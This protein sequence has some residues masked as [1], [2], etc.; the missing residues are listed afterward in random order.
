MI[1]AIKKQDANG[2]SMPIDEDGGLTQ[3]RFYAGDVIF[4]EGM[5]SSHMYVVKEGEVDIY[6]IREE[7]RVVVESLVRG[8]CFGMAPCLLSGSRTTNAAAK[9]YCEL[10]LVENDKLDE[11]LNTSAKLVRGILRTL[12]EQAAV[13]NELIA[14]RVNYQPDILVYA[15]LLY[16][17]GIADIGKLKA[18]AVSSQAHSA[19][20]S[21]TLSDVFSSARALLGHSDAHIRGSMGKLAMLHLIRIADEKGN[22]KRVLFAPKDIISQARKIASADKDHG[23]LDY[24]YIN[25]DEFSALVD[26]DRGIILKKLA[27][28]E[29][30]ED[31][32][33]FRK[34]EIMRLL[35]D[36]GRK[37]FIDRKIKSPEEFTDIVDIEFADQKTCFEVISRCD[38]YDL[39]KLVGNTDDAIVKSRIL[40]C[41][42]RAKQEELESDISGLKQ[43]DPIEVQQIGKAIIQ[44]IKEKMLK[45]G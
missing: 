21:P 38:V 24:E 37:F 13:A 19:Q 6:M 16:I 44:D 43:V 1:Q 35:N 20:A 2:V 9:T 7:K 12:A 14:T 29:F 32:F 3:Q 23:K 31:I 26:V 30:A 39:A 33:T 18:E 42:P 41:L 17:L 15:Q 34:S 5:S 40:A 25:V 28:G 27:G 22:G 36:K 10:Y 11:A 45:R 8:Q 4:T